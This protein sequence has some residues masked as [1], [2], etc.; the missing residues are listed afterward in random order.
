M[1]RACSVTRRAC[2]VEATRT[3]LWRAVSEQTTHTYAAR[4]TQQQSQRNFNIMAKGW[5]SKA[6]E[7]QQE[8]AA[9]TQA[10]P[11]SSAPSTDDAERRQRRESLQLTRSH[12]LTQLKNSQ[13]VSHR[14]MLHQ[15]LRALE[16]EL[17]GL[18]DK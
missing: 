9:R 15:S 18:T 6:V 5:E 7:E 12:L 10:A 4:H 8:E 3:S 14:Q 2:Y 1:A 13:M 11:E 16:E 17:A